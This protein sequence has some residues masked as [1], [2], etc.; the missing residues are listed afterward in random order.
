MT[1]VLQRDVMNEIF[2][3]EMLDVGEHKPSPSPSHARPSPPSQIQTPLS[4]TS[5][6]AKP[7][8]EVCIYDIP[9]FSAPTDNPFP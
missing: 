6:S 7:I 5:H 1:A 2:T 8:G 4:G 3:V 9:R